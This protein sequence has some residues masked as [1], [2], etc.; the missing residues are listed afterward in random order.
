MRTILNSPFYQSARNQKIIV[1]IF[2]GLF[3]V[4]GLGVFKDYGINF[5]EHWCRENG[6][7]NAKY[8]AKK[9]APSLLEGNRYCPECKDLEGYSDA[10]HGPIF[11]L[12]PTF[13]E[14]AFN[15]RDL[16]PAFLLRHLTIFLLY[17]LSCWFFYLI[18]QERF[19]KPLLSLL[20]VAI[21]ILSPRIF[22]ESFF[23]SKDLPFLSMSVISIYTLLRYL[24]NPSVKTVIWH[25]LACAL[26]IDMRLLGLIFPA[27]TLGFSILD[28]NIFRKDGRQAGKTFG[29]LFLYLALLLGFVILFWP[30]LWNK[31]FVKIPFLLQKTSQYPWPANMLYNGTPIKATNL[32]WH[33][34]PNWFFITTPIGYT[35][36]FLTGLVYILIRFFKNKFLFYRDAW[37]RQD[38]ILAGVFVIPVMAAIILKLVL[39]DAWRHMYFIYPAFVYV[40]VV[41]FY[42]L[43]QRFSTVRNVRNARL[44]RNGLVAILL[45]YMATMAFWIIKNHPH[46]NVFFSI[47]K[48]DSVR[49]KFE[50]DYW[51]LSYKQG[52][53]FVLQ[54]TDKPVIKVMISTLPGVTNQFIIPKEERKRL[55]YVQTVAEADYFLTDYRWH[56]TDY[57]LKE[58]ALKIK[59]DDIKIFS[60]FRLDSLSD[61]DTKYFFTY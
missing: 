50:L 6:V 42:T 20:G 19:R 31:P 17:W 51:G 3:L 53:E 46:Q 7:V 22:A 56:P 29:L 8:I 26:A 43:Y 44:L 1:A 21:L 12:V 23:N 9:L 37:E 36:L 47:Y 14:W 54:D 24:K 18:L 48:D 52:L 49:Q 4:V 40:A 35:L 25:A 15:I 5:D 34:L 45:A 16:R 13:F 57:P 11:E 39:Y 41:G 30:Y 28:L 61:Y 58:E 27:L 10:D 32:P 55:Q 38:L 2:F 60:V 33:Y 59:V